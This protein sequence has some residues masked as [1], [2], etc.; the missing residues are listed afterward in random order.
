MAALALLQ[1][2]TD[3]VTFIRALP[4]LHRVAC[5]DFKSK[6]LFL[7]ILKLWLSDK[8]TRNYDEAIS[9]T[10]ILRFLAKAQES[11]HT[12]E[13]KNALDVIVMNARGFAPAEYLEGAD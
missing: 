9:S 11:H 6:S 7:M 10:D 4:A 5:A 13:E 8:E 2:D 12:T 1:R 3:S